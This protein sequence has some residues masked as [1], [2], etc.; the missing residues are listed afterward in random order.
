MAHDKPAISDEQIVELYRSGFSQND[1]AEKYHVSVQHTRAVL[2]E[3]GFNTRGY[4]A[5][6]D[7]MKT[8]VLT[9]VRNGV[10]YLDIERVTDIAFHAIRELVNSKRIPPSSLENRSPSPPVK[11]I[12]S[13]HEFPERDEILAKYE[14]G[15]SFCVLV[16]EYSLDEDSILKFYLS[17]SDGSVSRH[18]ASMK[19]SVF[20]D[21]GVG[22]SLGVIARKNSIS[23]AVARKYS[24]A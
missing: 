11:I 16:D 2:K 10:Y 1:I 6:N 4:R 7:T 8:V 3:A 14:H 19:K 17:I 23:K 18:K 13:L 5:L 12:P 20:T 21:L 15:T 9:L 22:L 24:E